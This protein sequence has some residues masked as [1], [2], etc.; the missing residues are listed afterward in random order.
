MG[1]WVAN[2]GANKAWQVEAEIRV[3]STTRA[4]PR[5]PRAG[6]CGSAECS[7]AFCDECL[8]AHFQCSV[9]ATRFSVLPLRCPAPGCR[10]RVPLEVTGGAWHLLR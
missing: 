1:S 2:T 9:E 6:L 7:L 3:A 10:R 8:A 5:L 4:L